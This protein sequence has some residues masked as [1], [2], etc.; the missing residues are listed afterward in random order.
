MDI[1]HIFYCNDSLANASLGFSKKSCMVIRCSL[2]K[3]A[4]PW[5][6]VVEYYWLAFATCS[7]SDRFRGVMVLGRLEPAFPSLCG[8][9]HSWEV[10]KASFTDDRSDMDLQQ[11]LWLDWVV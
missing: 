1:G 11:S 6:L 2:F 10:S 4:P 3:T 9:L 7:C 5:Y 8:E